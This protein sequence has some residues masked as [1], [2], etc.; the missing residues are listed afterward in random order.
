MKRFVVLLFS[1]YMVFV[2]IGS[3]QAEITFVTQ[4]ISLGG[5]D[6]VDWGTL[7][8]AIMTVDNPILIVSNLGL[9]MSI[10]MPQAGYSFRRV[11]QWSGIDPFTGWDG[12]F[13]VG[14]KA[15]WTGY[16]PSPLAYHNGPMTIVFSN[17]VF[18]AGAQIQAN[19]P[20]TFTATIEAYDSADASLGLFIAN[21]NWNTKRDNSAIFIGIKSD[22]ANIGKLVF[23]VTQVTPAPFKG[24]LGFAINRL[25]L[26]DT[27]ISPA[28]PSIQSG[29]T[30]VS[31]RPQL[32]WQAVN[33]AIS[34]DLYLWKEGE[35]KPAMPTI[36]ELTGAMTTLAEP[37]FPLTI[38]RWQVI[39][40]NSS[41][42]TLGPEWTFTT[43]NFLIGDVNDDKAENLLD[44]ILALRTIDGLYPVG[45]RADYTISG[46]DVN[47][48]GKVGMEE[49]IYII[50]RVALLRVPPFQCPCS[51]PLAPAGF[52]S[53]PY[54]P[55]ERV[56]IALYLPVCGCD[57]Q[58][59]GN[60]CEAIRAGVPVAYNG[61]CSL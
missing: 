6:F 36:K 18:G 13:A 53:G 41:G 56:C 2:L 44:A 34:Y 35:T 57:G 33:G 7:G 39:A 59:Y 20:G 46:V 23:N 58:T 49:V 48:D 52:C 1:L 19:E 11:D 37:L 42:Q 27:G 25:D 55:I 32:A 40:R 17:P 15:L 21:G 61:E 29:A 51:T 4:R 45:I 12:N 26:V 28:N 43:G 50:Q 22:T 16:D 5:N 10:S 3:A 31:I 30:N 8:A 14:D 9:S 54:T 47:N 60:E 24:D 38:Y